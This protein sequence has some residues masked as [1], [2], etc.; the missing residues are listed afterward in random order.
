M[1]DTHLGRE[2]RGIVATAVGMTGE[3][4]YDMYRLPALAK[5]D[6]RYVSPAAHAGKPRRG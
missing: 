3:Q 6:E 1:R 4:V 2:P 5:Y